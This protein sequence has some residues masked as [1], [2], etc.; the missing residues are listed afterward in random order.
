[1]TEVM[2]VAIITG[3]FSLAGNFIAGHLGN[4]KTRALIDY[5]LNIIEKK[6]D[7]YNGVIARQ[8]EL[9]KKVE[10]LENRESVSEHRLEDLEKGA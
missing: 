3:V 9:E 6:Q 5:R 2:W 4:N 8:Y 10:V 7:K 1:M